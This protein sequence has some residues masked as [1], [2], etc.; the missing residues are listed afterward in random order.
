VVI[1]STLLFFTFFGKLCHDHNNGTETVDMC[2]KFRTEIMATG[3]VIFGLANVILLT[4]YFR[5]RL[6]FEFFYY[7]HIIMVFAM[8][9]GTLVHTLDDEFRKGSKV[10]KHRSQTFRWVIGSVAIY[11]ADRSWRY[12]T[13]E[14][15]VPVLSSHCHADGGS[16]TL[17][18]LKPWWF[19]FLPGQYLHLQIPAI[20]SMWHPFSIGS[21]P[22]SS[23]LTVIIEVSPNQVEWTAQVAAMVRC[24][25][26]VRVNI[27]GPFGNPVG[28]DANSPAAANIIAVG[29]GTGIV[30]MLSM[31]KA[32][33]ERLG[34]LSAS[35]LQRTQSTLAQRQLAANQ[36]Y[37]LG[38]KVTPSTNERVRHMQLTYRAAR[39]AAF[40]RGEK[41]MPVFLKHATASAGSYGGVMLSVAAMLW[42][43][44][45]GA[46]TALV[47]SWSNLMAVADVTPGM[48][49]VLEYS[50]MLLIVPYACIVATWIVCRSR[51]EQNPSL[52]IHVLALIAMVGVVLAFTVYGKYASLCS[53]EQ[54]T[55]VVFSV[56][57]VGAAWAH[58][59]RVS[60]TEHGG[61]ASSNPVESFRMLWATRS[62]ELV[63]G[64]LQ[65]LEKTFSDL[66][67]SMNTGT[68]TKVVG[69]EAFPQLEIHVYCTDT[70]PHHIGE[71]KAW[72]QGTR[73]ESLVSFS[74]AELGPELVTSMRRH[75][76]APSFMNRLPGEKKTCAVTFCGSPIVSDALFRAVRRCGQLATVAGASDF[77]FSFRTESYSNMPVGKT[78]TL[79][80]KLDAGYVVPTLQ[81]KASPSPLKSSS[82]FSEKHLESR[83]LSK[84]EKEQAKSDEW[85]AMR[86]SLTGPGSIHPV[87][88][89]HPE[90]IAKKMPTSSSPAARR[91]RPS[92]PLRPSQVVE[93]P[94]E[95]FWDTSATTYRL[96]HH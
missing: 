90:N 93:S 12:L 56:W 80:A 51:A 26:L 21:A 9:A 46:S 11:I 49:S 47:L 39:L 53:T 42:I 50:T 87:L 61:Y 3:L 13:Q 96:T 37:C 38:A 81:T 84:L 43:C 41:P 32:R 19:S 59:S 15:E 34:Q 16:V 76:M 1:I 29:S 66:E 63:I 17:Q 8:Y 25:S 72:L 89:S 94:P 64:V 52:Y 27:R 35:G 60:R 48:V 54:A 95:V 2:S 82:G 20:N 69:T 83:R 6:K 74:R 30:P 40:E 44:L 31:L 7:L 57:R 36:A 75:I 23:F 45:E 24:G 65:D 67:A 79:N 18:I 28:P 58:R 78:R 55:L 71:L 5:G 33:A 14:S 70:N 10:G 92:K 85:T 4:S 68:D 73:F 88:T 86:Q 91:S 62:A 22:E 77:Q